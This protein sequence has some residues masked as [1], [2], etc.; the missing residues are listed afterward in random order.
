MRLGIDDL[1]T[2]LRQR[3]ARFKHPKDLIVVDQ[4]PRNASNKIRKNVLREAYGSPD[5]GLNRTP[6]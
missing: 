3:L 6:V 4:M 1:V 5:S 2:F